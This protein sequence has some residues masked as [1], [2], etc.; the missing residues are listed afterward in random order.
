MSTPAFTELTSMPLKLERDLGM[1]DSGIDA[2]CYRH[3]GQMSNTQYVHLN[4]ENFY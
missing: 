2:L 1:Y 4:N 3:M